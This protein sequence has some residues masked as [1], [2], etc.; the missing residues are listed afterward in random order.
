MTH[1]A[2]RCSYAAV[3][4]NNNSIPHLS[5]HRQRLE[6]REKDTDDQVI[7]VKFGDQNHG[8]CS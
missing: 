5:D 6:C 8:D 7:D 1:N 3:A 4:L 2:E